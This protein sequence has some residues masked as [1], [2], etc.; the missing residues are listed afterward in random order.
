VAQVVGLLLALVLLALGQEP[1]PGAEALGLAAL[2]GALGSLGLGCFYLALSRGTMGLVAPLTALIAATVPAVVGIASGA[3]VPLLTGVGM[4]V[5]LIAVVLIA[6]PDRRLGRPVLATLH[7]S[8][9]WEWALIVL[10]G[11]GFAGFFMAVDRSNAAGGEVWWTL[12]MVKVA[13][14][15]AV[16]LAGLVIV[17]VGRA[18]PV[19]ARRAGL[20][21][22]SLAGVG[23]LGGNLFFVLASGVGDLAVVVV[24]SSLYPVSTAIL[25]RIF[26][27]ERLGPI[28]LVGVA[29]AVTGVA[30]ISVGSL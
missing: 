23:D 17:G 5:A 21:V 26:V 29:L 12:A 3:H 19:R 27:H 4:A 11:L 20:L 6:L 10:A 8:R 7:R 22:A 1:M 24:L 18:P 2:G 25:A 9:R 30:L 15:A 16:G 28:R 13:G 14:V